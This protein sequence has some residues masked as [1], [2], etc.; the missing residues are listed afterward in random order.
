[1]ERVQPSWSCMRSSISGGGNKHAQAPATEGLAPEPAGGASDTVE[2]SA[3]IADHTRLGRDLAQ[4]GTAVVHDHCIALLARSHSGAF[5]FRSCPDLPTIFFCSFFWNEG[6][7][8]SRHAD[9]PVHVTGPKPPRVPYG[10]HVHTKFMRGAFSI[11]RRCL[12][13]RA[14]G[15]PAVDANQCSRVQII[16]RRHR[17][18]TSS[19]SPS[20]DPAR[21]SRR[22]ELTPASPHRPV[23]RYR[24]STLHQSTD[25][26]H[27]AVVRF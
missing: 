20:A 27:S 8:L 14:R 11:R 22:K 9:S 6:D 2:V 18:A 13:A 7:K 24:S 21:Q 5:T 25:V 3:L 23:L 10:Y 4:A 12:D 19:S 15:W 16:C 17:N 1:M 26:P